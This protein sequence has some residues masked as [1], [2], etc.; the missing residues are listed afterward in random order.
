MSVLCPSKGAILDENE[1]DWGH[2]FVPR[3]GKKN[4]IQIDRSLSPP[5]LLSE[6]V[7]LPWAIIDSHWAITQPHLLKQLRE[8]GAKLL[9]DSQAWRYRE[10]ATFEVAKSNFLTALRSPSRALAAPFGTSFGGRSQPR[11]RSKRRPIS[12]LALCPAIPTTTSDR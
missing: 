8:A 10:G 3:V 4:S 2:G 1:F 6:P 11:P 9:F 5:N 7:E 12:Y